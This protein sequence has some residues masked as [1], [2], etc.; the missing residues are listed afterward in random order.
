T[1]SGSNKRKSPAFRA[2]LRYQFRQR[3]SLSSRLD[4][5]GPAVLGTLHFELHHTFDLGEDC[6]VFADTNVTT[7]MELCSTLTN[8]D[9]TSLHHLTTETLDAKAFTFGVATVTGT[10]TRLLVSH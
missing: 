7:R 1:G 6:V 9:V 5:N 10:T 3:C 2:G 8:D 4:R